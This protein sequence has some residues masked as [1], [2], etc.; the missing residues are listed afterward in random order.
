MDFL[1]TGLPHLEGITNFGDN[2]D[3]EWL[4]VYLLYRLT[5][6]DPNLVIK[7]DDSDGEFL[8]IEA[9]NHLPKWCEPSNSENR[10][11]IYIEKRFI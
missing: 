8:L 11:F 7:V 9:A 6:F 10:V 4:V 3:D 2:I 5:G 1:S